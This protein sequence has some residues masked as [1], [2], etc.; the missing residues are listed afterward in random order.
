MTMADD[1]PAS[2]ELEPEDLDDVSGGFN[3]QPDPPGK[4]E[5]SQ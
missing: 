5:H 4:P 3:P 2:T 1:K